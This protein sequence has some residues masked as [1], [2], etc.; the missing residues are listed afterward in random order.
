MGWKEILDDSLLGVADGIAQLDSNGK[1]AQNVDA[2][3]V[4]GTLA[5][6]NIPTLAIS[7]VSNLQTEL[8]NKLATKQDVIDTG[9]SYSDVGA[10]ADSY[11]PS[12]TEIL[13]TGLDYSDI[14][15]KPDSYTPSKTEILSTGLATNDIIPDETSLPASGNPGEM[16]RVSGK[17]YMWVA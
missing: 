14:G 7:K 15:A 5:T 17:L 10:K 8:D 13:S 2:S 1:V 6:T 12:K 4:D 9:L 3:K 11:T 16:C